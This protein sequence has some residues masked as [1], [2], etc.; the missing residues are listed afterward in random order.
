MPP[1]GHALA[2]ALVGE[3]AAITEGLPELL[4]PPPPLPPPPLHAAN[5][6]ATI[7]TK[8]LVVASFL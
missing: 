6:I 3:I 2:G 8:A 5:A 7:P 4:P 1:F